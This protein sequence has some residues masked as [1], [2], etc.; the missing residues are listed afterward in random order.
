VHAVEF[1]ENELLSDFGDLEGEVGWLFTP[2]DL[3]HAARGL[4]RAR[5]R[6]C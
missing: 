4:E 1:D 5:P 3:E 2:D 6:L